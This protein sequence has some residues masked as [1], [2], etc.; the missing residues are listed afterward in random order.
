MI[1]L[2]CFA[3]L[4]LSCGKESEEPSE[5]EKKPLSLSVKELTFPYTSNTKTITITP[6]QERIDVTVTHPGNEWCSTELRGSTLYVTV[7]KNDTFAKRE[8]TVTVTTERE[9]CSLPVT[10]ET[11]DFL[12][13]AKRIPLGGNAYV[14]TEGG[15][16][17]VT[18]AGF[19]TWIDPG[20]VFSTFFRVNVAGELKLYLEYATDAH[21][22][23]IEVT[24][25]GETFAVTLPKPTRQNDTIVYVGTVNVLQAGYARVDCKG[26]VKNGNTYAVPSALYIYGQAAESTNYVNDFS[27]Y[28]GRRGP[29]VH[30]SYT[31]PATKQAEWFY[32]EVTVPS[33]YDTVGSYFMSN[34]FGQGYF[35]IQVNSKTERRVLFSV[36]SPYSTDNPADIPEEYRVKLVKKGENVRTGEFGNEGSGGQSYLVYHWKAGHTYRF[37]TRIR[38]ADDGYSEYTS[39]F[40]APEIGKWQLIAQFL[41]PKT[42]TWYTNAH[43]FLE[44][45]STNTG[46]ITRKASYNN[47]WV[48]TNEGEWEELTKGK[49]TTDDTGRSG[50]RMDHK[51]GADSAGFFLQN[52]GFFNDYTIP[53]TFFERT[54]NGVPPQIDWDEVI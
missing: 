15:Y 42:T 23:Q 33:G 7:K 10:Q 1:K 25:Q 48:R 12:S 47:Q 8:T 46:Y 41:R 13:V 17:S 16:G 35:G 43:S 18:D 45:F 24:C 36:W 38:P 5:P 50:A 26:N 34:G 30:V 49:F 20:V 21:Q 44:N 28:W 3:L 4:F 37:L 14:T 29:S 11:V 51:G 52:C 53:D 54:P 39:Y 2:I 40:F 32:N 22:N 19:A 9:T 6:E 31:M 27:F